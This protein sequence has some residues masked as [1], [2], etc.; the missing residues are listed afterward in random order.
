[1]KHQDIKQIGEEKK[2]YL[3][4]TFIIKKVKKGT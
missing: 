1:M 4:Y 3:A 2:A